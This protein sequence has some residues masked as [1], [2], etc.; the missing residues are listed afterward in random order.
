MLDL[1]SKQKIVNKT[2]S[3]FLIQ[4]LDEGLKN[5]NNTSSRK[6]E[7]S[8]EELEDLNFLLKSGKVLCKLVS[9]IVPGIEIDV[10]KLE[11]K[12]FNVFIF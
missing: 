4:V 7:K 10:D 2:V 12:P 8:V 1:A 6:K 9:K 5:N 11:V 3:K